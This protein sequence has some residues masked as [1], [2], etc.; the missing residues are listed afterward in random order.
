MKVNSYDE[1]SGELKLQGYACVE[2]TDTDQDF[3]KFNQVIDI[4]EFKGKVY[5]KSKNHYLGTFKL[6]RVYQGGLYEN[7][8]S[9]RIDTVF[10]S[11]TVF[12][13]YIFYV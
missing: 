12:N 2:K 4:N 6:Y 9:N 10:N 1:S 7:I 5:N 3:T 11:N 8:Y 13:S